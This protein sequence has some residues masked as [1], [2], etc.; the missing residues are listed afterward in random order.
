MIINEET[1]RM[2]IEKNA[3]LDSGAASIFIGGW[4]FLKMNHRINGW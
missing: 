4:Y 1:T 2:K 3:V